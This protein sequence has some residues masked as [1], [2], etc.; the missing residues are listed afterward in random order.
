VPF[1]LA[2]AEIL[3]SAENVIRLIHVDTC[4]FG[5]TSEGERLIDMNISGSAELSTS[6]QAS[7]KESFQEIVKKLNTYTSPRERVS[8]LMYDAMQEAD[9][10][11]SFLFAWAALEI[12]V[13]TS[14]SNLIVTEFPDKEIPDAYRDRIAKLFSDPNRGRTISSLA[15]KYAYLSVFIWKFL[16]CDDYDEFIKAKKTR[17]NF[18][19]GDKIIP[20]AL[21]T[22]KIMHLLNKII[23]NA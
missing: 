16:N 17:D 11:K 5:E 18:F 20:S 6:T 10:M 2:I 8:R 15:Q 22:R 19:H 21:P 4:K 7:L 14:F 23:K 9:K 3:T 1:T 12:F 13:N